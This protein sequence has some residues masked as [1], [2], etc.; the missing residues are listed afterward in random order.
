MKTTHIPG[1]HQG[2]ANG[3]TLGAIPFTSTCPKCA[4]VR[5]QRGYDRDS[6]LRLLNGGYPVEAYCEM[7]D[8]FWPTSLKERVRL[9]TA[10]IAQPSPLESL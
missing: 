1:F 10:A 4:H 8:E 2:K 9:I 6:L 3:H 5:A 7:C